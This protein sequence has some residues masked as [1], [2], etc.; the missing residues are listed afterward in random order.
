MPALDTKS[1]PKADKVENKPTVENKPAEETRGKSPILMISICVVLV[2][3]LGTAGFFAAPYIKAKFK[4]SG[5]V[6]EEVKATLA[7]EPFLVNLADKEEVRFIK[8]TFQLGLA[9]EPAEEAKNSVAIA[10]IRDSIISLLSSKTADQ[11]LTP[12]GKDKLRE[13]VRARIRSLAPR[14]KVLE[15]YIVDFVVQL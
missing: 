7:L 13:E 12:E 14:M 8:T 4:K 5:P 10:S 11:I 3:V 15:V 2:I 9:E 6:R 1:K